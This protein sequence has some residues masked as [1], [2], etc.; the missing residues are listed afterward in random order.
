MRAREAI[1][2]AVDAPSLIRILLAGYAR[3]V[4]ALLTS[5]HFG[6]D[7]KISGYPQDLAKVKQM[8]A[9]SGHPGGLT[10][11]FTTS[12]TYDQRIIQAI[13]GQLE[14]AGVTVRTQ[15]YD[16]GTYLQKIQSPQHDWGDLRYGQWSCSCLDA[17]GVI[18]PLFH[19]GSI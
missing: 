19:T 2:H 10:L 5:R 6:Y 17:D 15:S 9:E 16:F 13:Q 8:L 4:T 18:Y 11:V 12:P 14:Q 7:P 1:A 3:S